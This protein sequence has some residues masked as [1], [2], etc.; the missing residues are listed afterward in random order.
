MFTVT[1]LS[2]RLSPNESLELTVTA[3]VDDNYKFSDHLNILVSRGVNFTIF[4]SIEGVGTTIISD[5]PLQPAI[6][7]G[8]Y[9]SQAHFRR[10]FKLTNKG[11]RVQALSWITEGFSA[12]KYKRALRTASSRDV[13]D[14]SHK[15]KI[16]EEELKEPLFQIK[17]E[18]LV[19]EPFESTTI[20]LHGISDM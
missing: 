13:H 5:P 6:N 18:K 2:A 10:H 12:I 1:P 14:L 17:Q 4:L 20:T 16:A 19:L 7:L 8:T 9:Y 15:S 3:F 11:R